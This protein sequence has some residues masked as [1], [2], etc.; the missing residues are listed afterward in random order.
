MGGG[1]ILM[2]MCLRTDTSLYTYLT[3]AQTLCGVRN[4]FA[5]S[6]ALR[7]AYVKNSAK[8]TCPLPR[9]SG[10]TKLWSDLSDVNFT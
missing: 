6:Q 1:N 8:G 9:K 5:L 3:S 10:T 7:G 2:L 4:L